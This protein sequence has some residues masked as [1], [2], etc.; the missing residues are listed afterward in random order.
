MKHKETLVNCFDYQIV[1]DM[2]SYSV[3]RDSVR[4]EVLGSQWIRI[5]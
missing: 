2:L 1:W 3:E 4:R 5:V